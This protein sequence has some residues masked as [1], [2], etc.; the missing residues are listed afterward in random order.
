[1]VLLVASR[2]Y[3]ASEYRV[4][5][6]GQISRAYSRAWLLLGTRDSGLGTWSD[7]IRKNHRL[8]QV[9]PRIDGVKNLWNTKNLVEK[10]CP[11]LSSN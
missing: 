5:D 10:R 7:K 1:M 11:V 6:K 9:R 2:E 3:L 8:R 4:A